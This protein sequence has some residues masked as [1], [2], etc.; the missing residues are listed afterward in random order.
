MVNTKNQFSSLRVKLEDSNRRF[1]MRTTQGQYLN[2]GFRY[3]PQQSEGLVYDAEQAGL[4]RLADLNQKEAQALQMALQ[5]KNADDYK[6]LAQYTSDVRNIQADRLTTLDKMNTQ[7]KTIEDTDKNMRNMNANE[8]SIMNSM[9]SAYAVTAKEMNAKET[10]IYYDQ[11]AK[12][13]SEVMGFDIPKAII[14]S[15]VEGYAE[16]KAEKDRIDNLTVSKDLSTAN[17]YYTNINGTP[18]TGDDGKNIPYA[19][20]DWLSQLVGDTMNIGTYDEDGNRVI[21]SYKLAGAPPPK[22]TSYED[23]VGN[24]PPTQVNQVVVS[25]S[26]L[27]K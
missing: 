20:E 19:Q 15:S 17:K 13:L 4:A 11:K 12:E 7:I 27:Y 9:I 1:L 8:S 3:T 22:E 6:A 25:L 24:L 16:G 18:I 10:E 5:A 26:Q 23:T 2:N 21:K 14:K